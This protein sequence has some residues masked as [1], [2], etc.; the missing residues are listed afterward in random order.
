MLNKDKHKKH[1]FT[2]KQIVS[3]S[4][5]LYWPRT[6]LI[7]ILFLFVVVLIIIRLLWLQFIDNKFYINQESLRTK[8]VVSSFAHRGNIF[9]VNNQA[10]AVSVK[11]YSLW[12]NCKQFDSF[13]VLPQLAKIINM[14]LANLTSLINKNK[15]KQFV[16]IK[17]GISED[18]SQAIEQLKI[19]QLSLIPDYKRFYPYGESTAQLL[20]LTDIDDFGIEGL[21]YANNDILH[22][23]H[24]QNKIIKD[25]LGNIIYTENI[26]NISDNLNGGDVFLSIDIRL[27]DLA[28]KILKSSVDQVQADGG[29]MVILDAH[30][31]SVLAMSNYPSYNPN[32]QSQV[33]FSRMRNRAVTDIYEPG[34]TM[35]PFIVAKALE[36]SLVTL[37]TVLDTHPYQI[38]HKIYRDFGFYPE[39]SVRDILI[40]SSDIGMIKIASK[41]DH[42]ELWEYLRQLGFDQKVGVKLPG[43]AKGQLLNWQ[44]W[45]PQDVASLSFGYALAVSSLQIARAFTV[46]TNHGCLL[47][48]SFYKKPDGQAIDCEQ[49]IKPSTANSI[50]QILTDVINKGTGKKSQLDSYQVAGKTGTAHKISKYGYEKN[51]Y[52]GS[53]V[54]FAPSDNP[55]IIIAIMIDN[56]KGKHYTGG[57]V[58]APVFQAIA[59][60]ALQT[61]E[62]KPDKNITNS[63]LL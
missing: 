41:L 1:Q 53:F 59:P 44:K 24:M 27:Q 62:V 56:P 23:R 4:K 17:K 60:I 36:K 28:Y 31:G 51:Q 18:Q 30:N 34:S 9:D 25:L 50:A 61:L 55:K 52:V 48:V 11:I 13:E 20:G 16:F 46:F 12:L 7:F 33:S 63:L 57:F 45:T 42:Q 37:D 54:G 14:P 6:R 40:H 22:P 3:Q 26:A 2:N 8:R 58:A 32:N 35:K 43:E 5:L 15:T 19:S 29:S 49:V 10:L 21:E 47:P 38:G 39:L